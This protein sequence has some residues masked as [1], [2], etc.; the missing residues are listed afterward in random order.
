MLQAVGPDFNDSARPWGYVSAR[1]SRLTAL[2]SLDLPARTSKFVLV[3]GSLRIEGAD[4]PPEALFALAEPVDIALPPG[5]RW[6]VHALSEA[7]IV[8]YSER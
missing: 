7:V 2:Q 1:V 3:S 6:S 5:A 8:I 4:A